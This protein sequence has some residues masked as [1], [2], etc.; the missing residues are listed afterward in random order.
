M[1]KSTSQEYSSKA[2]KSQ[3]TKYTALKLR[4]LNIEFKAWI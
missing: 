1:V 4:D 2:T 3:D